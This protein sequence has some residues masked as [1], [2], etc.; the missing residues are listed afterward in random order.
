MSWDAQARLKAL[1]D[2]W[3]WDLWVVKGARELFSGTVLPEDEFGLAWAIS[4]PEPNFL[5][6]TWGLI[7]DLCHLFNWGKDVRIVAVGVYN[8]LLAHYSSK[9][10]VNW[11]HC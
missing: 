7:H 6:D 3:S 5:E 4:N 10:L 11:P 8:P 2:L 9:S 1:Y